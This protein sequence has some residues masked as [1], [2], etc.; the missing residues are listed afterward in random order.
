MLARFKWAILVFILFLAF[1]PVQILLATSQARNAQGFTLQTPGEAVFT[2]KQAGE[3]T[4]WFQNQ[5]ASGSSM[6]GFAMTAPA[7]FTIQLQR[8]S[9]QSPIAVTSGGMNKTVTI[10]TTQRV[11]FAAVQ[12]PEPGDYR[13]I[14][15]GS[16]E[17]RLVYF[18]KDY[19]GKLVIMTLS[20]GC[21]TAILFFLAV[22]L[23]IKAMMHKPAAGP[24]NDYQAV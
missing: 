18:S 7:G 11:S 14:A 17:P 1:I 8:E 3:Y 9:D 6:N 24:V 10:G 19:M 23:A 16:S 2:L 5:A 12:I 4:L 13:L 15:A 20:F 21:M 22:G